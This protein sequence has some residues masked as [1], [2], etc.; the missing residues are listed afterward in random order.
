MGLFSFEQELAIDLGTANTQIIHKDK[1]VVNSAFFVI[2]LWKNSFIVIIYI[3]FSYT[4]ETDLEAK[5]IF[6][7]NILIPT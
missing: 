3:N 4:A 6:Q 1:I 5:S 2:L 7:G